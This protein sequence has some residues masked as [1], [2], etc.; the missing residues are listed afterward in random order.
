MGMKVNA[1]LLCFCVIESQMQGEG[2]M[3]MI[4]SGD[5][6]WITILVIPSSYNFPSS[7]LRSVNGSSAVG[8]CSSATVGLS[9]WCHTPNTSVLFDGNIPALAG[10][11]GDMWA[12][13]LLTL[14][15]KVRSVTIYFDFTATP[16]YA[17]VEGGSCHVQL[18]WVGNISSKHYTSRWYSNS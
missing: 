5:W 14:R 17:G 12:S 11:D 9:S 16:G 13:Q 18:S 2:I 6:L 10:L 15:A 4:C 1:L 3:I 8:L 7:V